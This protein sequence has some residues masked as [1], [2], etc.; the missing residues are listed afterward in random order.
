MNLSLSTQLE[1]LIRR[2]VNAGLY[3]SPVQLV[4][5]ALQLLEERDALRDMRRDR[6]V[7]ELAGGVF[8]ADNRQLVDGAQVFQGLMKKATA[9][10]Q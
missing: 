8:E 10:D 6:L 2:K 1:E 3:E 9:S 7:R 5:E 4:E